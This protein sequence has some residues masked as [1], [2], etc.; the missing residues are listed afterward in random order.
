MR[1]TWGGEGEG[2]GAEEG[3]REAGC[4]RVGGGL[5]GT[6]DGAM[7]LISDEIWMQGGG[8]AEREREAKAER[9]GLDDIEAKS[10]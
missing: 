4:E 2:A 10:R 8:A 6:G 3:G 1:R 5:R 9:G 7:A